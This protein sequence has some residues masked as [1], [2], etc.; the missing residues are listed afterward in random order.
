MFVNCRIPCALSSLTLSSAFR[1]PFAKV[2][3]NVSRFGSGGLVLSKVSYFRTPP[4]LE[5]SF[6]RLFAKVLRVL[7]LRAC[8]GGDLSRSTRKLSEARK[9]DQM[10]AFDD[11]KIPE[12]RVRAA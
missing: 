5:L 10:L 8:P 6:L 9:E 4:I 12:I 2:P 3:C 7:K 1:D 11:D